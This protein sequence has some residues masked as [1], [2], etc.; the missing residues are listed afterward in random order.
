MRKETTRITGLSLLLALLLC[1]F[2]FTVMATSGDQAEDQTREKRTAEVA[3]GAKRVSLETQAILDRMQSESKKAEERF[4]QAMK[5][6]RESADSRE[7]LL[8]G[9]LLLLMLFLVGAVLL[10]AH[11]KRRDFRK[12]KLGSVA[13]APEQLISSANDNTVIQH[14]KGKTEYI[15][16]GRDEEGVR[17]VLTLS[18]EELAQHEGIILG[19]NPVDIRYLIN[20]PDVSR[21][22][23]RLSMSNNRVFV[24]DLGSTN[25]TSINGQSIDDKGPV[26]V[27]NGD[28][29]IIGSVVMKVRIEDESS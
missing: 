14:P 9:V 12:K 3:E 1:H 7:K 8:I 4:Q 28:Q 23:A 18:G 24:E 22:H 16:D 17:Y 19:R 5:E 2:S 11:Q 13:G 26:A 6:Q 25:G 27:A 29:V 10:Y 20:H 21:R 15:F